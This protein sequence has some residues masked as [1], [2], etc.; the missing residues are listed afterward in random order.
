MNTTFVKFPS[1]CQISGAMIL[2]GCTSSSDSGS[3]APA[4]PADAITIT[5]ANAT[6]TVTSAVATA[7]IALNAV[8]AEAAQAPTAMDIVNL[9]EDLRKNRTATSMLSTP[10]GA[11]QS[12]GCTG[13]GTI[14]YSYSST[15][16]TE[17]GSATFNSCT[18]SGFTLNGTLSFNSSWTD[19]YGPYSDHVSGSITATSGSYVISI[20]NLNFTNT[21]STVN[22]YGDAQ[23]TI[24]PFNYSINF[25]GGGGFAVTLLAP[26]TGDDTIDAVCPQAGTI[27]VTGAGSTKAKATIVYPNVTIE[28]DDGSGVFVQV[29][30]SPVACGTV[31]Q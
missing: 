1:I 18:E 28:Y 24:N 10:T 27:L 8:G 11:T 5:S 6:S 20:N 23:Y 16:T 14:D 9:V 4:V 29:P 15:L 7:N 12:I 3:S 21:G 19:P 26:V 25:T 22:D 2:A 17:S 30:E 13:G 31:F